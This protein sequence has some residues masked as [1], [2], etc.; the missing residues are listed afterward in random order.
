MTYDDVQS[1]IMN[2]EMEKMTVTQLDD[3][4]EFE[5]SK[6]SADHS[7]EYAHTDHLIVQKRCVLLTC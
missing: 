5:T 2:C 6:S 7:D 3:H 1:A 4:I